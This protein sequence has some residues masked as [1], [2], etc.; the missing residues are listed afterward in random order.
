MGGGGGGGRS[1][2]GKGWW[3]W[4]GGGGA[5]VEKDAAR[6]ERRAGKKR[7][8]AKLERGGR[9]RGGGGEKDKVMRVRSIPQGQEKRDNR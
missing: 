4:K 1:D 9:W 8:E 7:C 6:L 5:K 3:W 2:G